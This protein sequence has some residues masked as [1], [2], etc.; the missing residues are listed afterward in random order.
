MYIHQVP[1][2]SKKSPQCFISVVDASGSMSSYWR[3]LAVN[4]NKYIPKQNAITITF[5]STPRLCSDNTLK[6]NID[7]HGGGGTNITAA[8]EMMDTQ[9]AKIKVNQELTILFISDGQDNDIGSLERRLKLLKGSQGHTINFICL[10]IERQFPTF[11]SMYLREFYHNGLPSI[12]ALYLIEYY[13]PAALVNKFESMKEFFVHK[14]LLQVRPPVNVFPWLGPVPSVYEST[15]VLTSQ[16]QLEIEGK[17]HNA[18]ADGMSLDSIFELFRGYIQQL[19]MLSLSKNAQLKKYAA[20]TL[21]TMQSILNYYKKTEGIDPMKWVTDA[22]LLKVNFSERVKL[23]TLRHSQFRLKAYVESVENIAKGEEVKKMSEWEA[24]KKIGIGT[25]TGTYKQ[26]RFNLKKFTVDMYRKA[27]EDFVGVYEETKLVRGTEQEVSAT[28]KQAQKDVFL[29]KNFIQ[30]LKQCDSQ[31]ALIETLPVIGLAVKLKRS[32]KVTDDPWEN[33]VLAISQTAIN[34]LEL[35]HSNYK[36]PHADPKI[37]FVNCVLLLIGPKEKDMVPLISTRLFSVLITYVISRNADANYDDAYL[38]LLASCLVHLVDQPT[39]ERKEKMWNRIL[40]T[41]LMVYS[42]VK[43]IE[44]YWEKMI[45]TPEISVQGVNDLSKPFVL[46]AMKR[47]EVGKKNAET[48]LEHMYIKFFAKLVEGGKHVEYLKMTDSSVLDKVKSELITEFGRFNTLGELKRG[49]RVKME[50]FAGDFEYSPI[51]LNVPKLERVDQKVTLKK[52][53]SL[54]STFL[55]KAPD[56]GDYLYWLYAAIKSKGSKLASRPSA[57]EVQ[58][59]FFGVLKSSFLKSSAPTVY[60]ELKE[61]FLAKFREEHMYLLPMSITQLK[62]HCDSSNLNI[63]G[64]NYV[65]ELNLLKNA[66]MCPKCP[67][68][69]KPQQRLMHHLTTWTEKCPRAF[70][71]TLKANLTLSAE[72][73]LEKVLAGECSRVKAGVRQS[74]EEFGSNKSEALVYVKMLKEEYKKVIED[75]KNYSAEVKLIEDEISKPA[76]AFREER[77][78]PKKGPKAGAKHGQN[79][80]KQRF[81]GGGDFK[82]KR[83]D[84]HRR[85]YKEGEGRYRGDRRGKHRDGERREGRGRGRG[86]GRR[87]N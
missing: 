35:F 51:E 28:L 19:Q 26:K 82:G 23:H 61:G 67:F 47:E 78:R 12:P 50:G 15:W 66:C 72:A 16:P 30:A 76:A 3:E 24:A 85:E 74:L 44:E 32:L 13:T 31:F 8:F 65:K 49:V 63:K 38:A 14:K 27:L 7:V 53:N 2:T 20:E 70:H 48:V 79:V 80:R 41:I 56:K 46:L 43:V 83:G 87:R 81:G 55:H 1:H 69:L 9:I 22:D 62:E 36:L 59:Y 54:Y 34:S 64:Y 52:L 21:E 71:K 57:K 40:T 84:G 86:R 68:F 10:G 77:K 6:S 60:A 73:I 11:L 18:G 4:F 37:A 58:D 39:N 17:K 45:N 5:D 75:E 42:K 33:E 25:I 29:E